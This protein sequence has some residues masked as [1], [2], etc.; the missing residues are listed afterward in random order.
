[1]KRTSKNSY[2][3]SRFRGVSG[4]FLLGT[5]CDIKEKLK[6]LKMQLGSA[7]NFIQIWRIKAEK[8]GIKSQV[9]KLNSIFEG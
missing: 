4:R 5:L 7:D 8:K 3:G 2:G 9:E 6:L 1:M